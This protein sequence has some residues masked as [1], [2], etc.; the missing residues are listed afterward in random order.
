MFKSKMALLG[1]AAATALGLHLP[2]RGEHH[3]GRS[4]RPAGWR[5]AGR[6]SKYRP[7]QN[8]RECARRAAQLDRD[9]ER[10]I[11][12]SGRCDQRLSRRGKLLPGSAVD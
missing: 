8:E 2:G 7:H 5:A 12:R 6:S 3:R 9:R 4:A 10:Q 1:A 11:E